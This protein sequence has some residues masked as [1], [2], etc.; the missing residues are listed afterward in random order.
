MLK[1]LRPGWLVTTI[2]AG[3]A[4]PATAQ[5]LVTADRVGNPDAPNV[6]TVRLGTDH[7]PNTPHQELKVAF[8]EVWQKFAEAHP[9][10]QL[11]FEFYTDDIGGEHARLLEQARAGRAPDCVEVD[12][13]QL[14][15]FIQ[16]GVLRPLNAYFSEEEIAD[17]FPFIREGITGGD[18]EI[19]A[20]WWGTDLRV[21]YRNTDLVP[22]AP[23]TWDE[24]QAAALG[25]AGRGVEG[26]L[27]NGGRWEGTTFDWLA[28]FWSQGGDLVDDTGKPIFGEGDQRE[29]MLKAINFYKNLVDSGAAPKRVATITDYNDFNAAALAGTAAM[30]QGGHWQHFQL[31]ESMDPD[32][33]GKW[34][35]SELPGPT[36]DQRATGTGGWT[37]AAFSDDEDKI[38][39]CASLMREVYMGGANEVIGDLPTRQHLFETLPKFQ[40]PYFDQLKEYLAHGRARPGVPIYPEISNQIQI[41]MGEVL[42]GAEQPEAALD[43][44][45]NRVMDA[46][47]KR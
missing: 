21:L 42:S 45:W 5:E 13:F 1:S 23:A 3:L 33:F 38:A 4:A 37:V 9:D 18:G 44:A 34:Q 46:Y 8:T 24:L 29:K 47:G 11:Q 40:D 16:N 35:V 22:E 7:S 6:L 12:S 31:Q 14:A 39:M 28:H 27:F 43:D 20:W 19:Y 26:V 36:P 10:W 32:Q 30:F 41:M 17:L 15:L 25:A 2:L